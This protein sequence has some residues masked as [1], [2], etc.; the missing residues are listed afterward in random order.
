MT[1]P[2]AADEIKDF[3]VR[4]PPI[5]FRIDEDVF[6]APPAI[7][8]F[9]LR[10]LGGLHS[11]LGDVTGALATDAD[12]MDRIISVMGDPDADPPRPPAPA[13]I[14]LMDQAL[15]VLYY[16]LECYGL[17]PTQPSSPSPA[18]S[19]DGTPDTPSV[20]TSSTDG[21]WPEASPTTA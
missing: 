8:G 6:L 14:G 15:P 12:A 21:A 10:K 17:R 2:D 13:Q 18:G 4:R 3:T 16:L 11:Q 9:L 1:N 19:T 5:R 7:G 20:G